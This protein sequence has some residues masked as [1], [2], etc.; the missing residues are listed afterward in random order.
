MKPTTQAQKPTKF[1]SARFSANSSSPFF[2]RK[3]STGNN[4]DKICMRK[5]K[6]TL[7]GKEKATGLGNGETDV[8]SGPSAFCTSKTR[9]KIWSKIVMTID[10]PI[11]GGLDIADAKSVKAALV[12]PINFLTIPP[13]HFQSS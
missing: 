4:I 9:Q 11:E 5:E 7:A 3:T 12:W 8:A 13:P 10:P 1:I 6:A 2:P